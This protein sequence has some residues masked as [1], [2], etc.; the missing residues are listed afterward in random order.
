LT[1]SVLVC[2]QTDFVEHFE[3]SSSVGFGHSLTPQ[4]PSHVRSLPEAGIDFVSSSHNR[5]NVV[6]LLFSEEF[7][8]TCLSMEIS[9]VVLHVELAETCIEDLVSKLGFR[10]F[11]VLLPL[12]FIMRIVFGSLESG[13]DCTRSFT[14][15]ELGDGE[16]VNSSLGVGH[17]VSVNELHFFGVFI[18]RFA[19]FEELDVSDGTLT[20]L[21]GRIA[22]GILR[23]FC[24][25]SRTS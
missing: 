1:H 4:G 18:T 17:G 7:K 8:D 9:K 15:F 22:E 10:A 25:V 23:R 11:R 19:A 21:G 20:Q 14:H 2:N 13:A 12:E 6:R 16:A 24:S 5:R 3:V